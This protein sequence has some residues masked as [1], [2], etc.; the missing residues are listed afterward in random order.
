M[1]CN[2]CEECCYCHINPPCGFCIE[3]IECEICGQLVCL[4]KAVEVTD[5]SDGSKLTI[6]P[7]C[8]NAAL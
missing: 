5:M 6:C 7:D 8:E 2:F 4:D 3:H 1:S